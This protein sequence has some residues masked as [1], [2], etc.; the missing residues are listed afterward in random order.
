M[1]RLE[2][3]T[4]PDRTLSPEEQKRVMAMVSRMSDHRHVPAWAIWTAL[5]R[6]V[7]QQVWQVK[8]TEQ[9]ENH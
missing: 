8:Q 3:S 9:K 2:K 1:A 4:A 5:Y 7:A 6:F